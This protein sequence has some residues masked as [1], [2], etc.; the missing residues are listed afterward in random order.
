MAAINRLLIVDDTQ[1]ITDLVEVFAQAAGYEV[2]SINDSKL[3]EQA[4]DQIKPTVIFLDMTMPGRDG[5]ALIGSLASSNYPGRVV[6][7]SGS[8]L[9]DV[10]TRSTEIRSLIL[11]AVLLKPFRRQTVVELLKILSVT[12]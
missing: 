8:D 9:S 12:Q 6:I 5:M 10:K 3:F 4:L 11:P 2:L 7:M 1:E